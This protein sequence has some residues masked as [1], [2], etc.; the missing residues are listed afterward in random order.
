MEDRAE[1]RPEIEPYFWDT[2]RK[3]WEDTILA[4][5]EK[6]DLIIFDPPY[7]QKKA[8]S[9]GENSIAR[10]SRREYLNFL[11]MFFRFLKNS[12]RKTTRLALINS[13]WRDFQSCPALKEETQNAILLTDYYKILEG[14]GWELTH[15]IQA[16]LSSE[17]FNA[18]MV[19]AMQ[20]KKILGVTSRYIL[21]LEQKS[22]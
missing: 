2:K 12:T 3:N 13:D 11:D 17:R 15:I 7:F 6:P 5:R 8:D 10:M 21:L 18:I 1:R 19:S 16:P 9:Y 22:G 14:A 20:E 4:G